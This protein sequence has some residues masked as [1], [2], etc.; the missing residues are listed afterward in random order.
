MS[1]PDY[2]V[3]LRRLSLM[4]GGL[5]QPATALKPWAS[6][7]TSSWSRACCTSTRRPAQR[8]L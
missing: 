6:P 4:K 2:V 8:G 7:R 3:K 5:G 1:L